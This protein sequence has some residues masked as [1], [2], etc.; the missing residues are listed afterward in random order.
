MDG[1]GQLFREFVACL[2]E[3]IEPVI[4]RYPTDQCLSY[5]DLNEFVR[6]ACPDSAAFVVLAESFSTPLA[7]KYAAKNRANLIGVI[8]CA[9]FVTSPVPGWLRFLPP[10]SRL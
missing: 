7:I 1:T 5:D 6:I 3:T 10:C 4:V 8:L 9:G 2:P